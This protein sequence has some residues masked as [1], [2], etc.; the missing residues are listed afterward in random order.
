MKDKDLLKKAIRFGAAPNDA[1]IIA[2][3]TKDEV[4]LLFEDPEI[5]YIVEMAKLE[6]REMLFANRSDYG[7]NLWLC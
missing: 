5:L 7:D 4:A 6:L 3:Y 1:G 2:G